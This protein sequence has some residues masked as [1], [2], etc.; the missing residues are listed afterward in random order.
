MQRKF[1]SSFLLVLLLNVL[2]KP[3]WILGID[4]HVQNLVG[5]A[6][7]G[8][9][10]A[11][12]SFTLIFNVL[13][14]L[15]LTH[16]NNRAIAQNPVEIVKNF[17]KLTSLK[18]MLGGFYLLATLTVGVFIGYTTNFFLLLLILAVNQMLA[19]FVLFLRSH[20]AGL[21]LFKSDSF[22]SVADKVLMI[23][24]CGFLLYLPIL[25]RPFRVLDFALAQLASYLLT[26]LA[27]FFMVLRKA[28]IFRWHIRFSDFRN[29]LGQ[30]LPYALLI[31]L[32]A[33]Y[34]R[35]DSIMLE[36]LV[37]AFETGV[38]MQAFRLLDAVNQFAY[39]IGV[40]LLS[41]FARMLAQK[42][43]V[44]PITQ[45]SFGL[46]VVSTLAVSLASFFQAGPI[47]RLLY[48]S[49]TDL[50]T[51]VFQ[52]LIVSSVA[53]G[54]TYVFGTLL[55]ARGDVRIL[56][57]VALSGFLLN[58]ILNFILIPQYGASGAAA[59]TLV[60]QFLTAL[61]QLVISLRLAKIR[62]RAFYWGR[63]L[64]FVLTSALVAWLLSRSEADWSWRWIFTL[65][66]VPMVALPLRMFD[67][68]AAI[69]LLKSRFSQG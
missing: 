62:F 26:A 10:A 46:A 5:E 19:S 68:N 38:Y 63:F 22:L 53:F 1:I 37:G 25:N 69:Q 2:V 7:Y 59:T 58:I 35:V 66:S 28:R 43:D 56:N 21:Q 51:P 40:L 60:T 12:F 34:T 57:R 39:L 33:L 54:S 36:Q 47:L 42:Q 64:A 27:G 23:L 32:M 15:G 4:R 41:I 65:L 30:S 13:L 29:N 67:L 61:V 48:H 16:F 8:E 45:L 52:L 49:N 31:L 50:S 9:Y 3:V 11:L 20:L 14:D 24:I 55:T 44:G 17:S 18:L 6:A